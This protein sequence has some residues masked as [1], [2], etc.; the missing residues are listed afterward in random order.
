MKIDDSKKMA[1][2]ANEFLDTQKE[3]KRERKLAEK[4]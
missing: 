4:A 2:E 3:A 1:L